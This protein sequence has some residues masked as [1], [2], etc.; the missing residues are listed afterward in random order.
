M[1][2]ATGQDRDLAAGLDLTRSPAGTTWHLRR[3][4]VNTSCVELCSTHRAT[5]ASSSAKTRRSGADRRDHPP[6]RR[7]RVRLGPVGLARYRPC[8][9]PPPM[10][11][12]YAGVVEEIGSDVRIIKPGQFVVGSFFASD[13]TCE[14][15]L[16]GYQSRCVHVEFDRRERRAGRVPARP[17]GRRHPGRHVR[18]ARRRPGPQ[19]ARR[20][21]R[22]RH[23]LVRR[24]RRRRAGRA[25]PSRSSVTARSAC[26]PC[27]RPG[28][29]APSGSSR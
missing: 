25:R 3:K 7:L 5:S 11:H 27:S 10:G 21:R 13:N 17:A 8:R 22:A 24:R 6:V 28:S 26:S 19:P 4:E 2:P 1:A 16:A 12:E 14:I 9:G 23:R 18:S 20:L 29:W 15:C